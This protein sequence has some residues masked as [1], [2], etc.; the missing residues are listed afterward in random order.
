MFL[1]KLLKKSS[2][3]CG[4]ISAH[5]SI[6]KRKGEKNRAHTK[7]WI[8]KTEKGLTEPPSFSF[9]LFMQPTRL[10]CFA[11]SIF[12]LVLSRPRSLHRFHCLLYN[13]LWAYCLRLTFFFVCVCF[14]F[15]PL[16]VCFLSESFTG[17]C[18]FNKTHRT[19]WSWWVFFSFFS[20]NEFICMQYSVGLLPFWLAFLSLAVTVNYAVL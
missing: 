13:R 16:F 10:L 9:Y 7:K 6:S 20:E 8:T 15:Y 1:Q 17:D 18:G 3:A 11:S 5:Q 14:F 4:C 12:S 2:T 19:L